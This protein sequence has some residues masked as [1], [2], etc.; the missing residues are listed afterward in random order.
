LSAKEAYDFKTRVLLSQL[1]M[2]AS[3]LE[4]RHLQGSFE[5]SMGGEAKQEEWV[6]LK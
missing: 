6:L 3:D 4:A 2:G 1:T 5:L